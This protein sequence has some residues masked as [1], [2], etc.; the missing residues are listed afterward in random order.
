MSFLIGTSLSEQP[1]GP[2]QSAGVCAVHPTLER[3]SGPSVQGRTGEGVI[4]SL[5]VYIG[6]ERCTKVVL[7]RRDKTR[8]Y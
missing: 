4:L 3:A 8:K 5:V 6:R 2:P 7:E 1:D